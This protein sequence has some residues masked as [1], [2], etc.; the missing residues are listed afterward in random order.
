MPASS[1]NPLD[2]DDTEN[3][4]TMQSPKSVP[5]DAECPERENYHIY[6]EG[7]DI[8]TAMLN[9]TNLQNNNNKFYMIQLLENNHKKQFAVWRRWG[10][11]GNRGQ[12]D[13]SNYGNSL[14]EAKASFDDK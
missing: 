3:V 11:V 14:S 8:Y 12:S 5:V 9:Q 4:Q 10:R 1:F 13:F 7:T 2:I 6:C